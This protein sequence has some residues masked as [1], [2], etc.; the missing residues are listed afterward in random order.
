LADHPFSYGNKRTAMFI[1]FA[2]AEEENKIVNREL[3]LHHIQSIASKNINNIRQ[4]E[5]RLKNAIR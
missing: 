1:A 3:L 2:F 5:T 4:I